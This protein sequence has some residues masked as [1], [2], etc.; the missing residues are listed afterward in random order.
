MTTGE[1]DSSTQSPLTAHRL[2]LT[3]VLAVLV[4]SGI[5]PHDHFT[6]FLEVAPILIGLPIILLTRNR[7]PLTPLAYTLLAIHACIL[8]VGGH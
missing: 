4:W 3:A 2:L 5:H 1:R 7:F 6:W 8:A